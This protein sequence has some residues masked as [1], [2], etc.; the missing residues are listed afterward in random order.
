MKIITPG[1]AALALLAAPAFAQSDGGEIDDI[2]AAP[3][4]AAPLALPTESPVEAAPAAA[5]NAE[6]EYAT[7]DVRMTTSMGDIVIRLETERAPVT[8]RNFLR[9]VRE[10]RYNGMTFYRATNLAEGYGLVQGGTQGDPKMVLPPIAHEPT[11]ETGLSHLDGTISMAMGE[12]GTADGDFFI[13]VGDLVSLDA[14]DGA[15]GFAAFGR[16]T[17]GMDMIRNILAAPTDPN[18]GEGVMRGQF[19]A[20]PVRITSTAK[21]D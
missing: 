15:P 11:T 10:G 9:Y 2:N 4:D 21:I 5:A 14:K 8:S 3:A 12:P 13:I 20:D 17:E 18:R 16:V 6:P 1:I 19:L 7:A